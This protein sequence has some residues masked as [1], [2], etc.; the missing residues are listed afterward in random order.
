MKVL[1]LQDIYISYQKFYSAIFSSFPL[2]TIPPLLCI[3][4]KNT[5]HFSTTSSAKLH[6]ALLQLGLN[7]VEARDF[8]S[9]ARQLSVNGRATRKR[10]IEFNWESNAKREQKVFATSSAPSPDGFVYSK[11]HQPYL[12][13]AL[14]RMTCVNCRINRTE[15][16][17]QFTLSAA[18][19]HVQ[20]MRIMHFSSNRLAPDCSTNNFSR[21]LCLREL[22]E[23]LI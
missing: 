5:A 21:M 11:R 16:I 20:P 6:I 14:C 8:L 9:G 18:N 3:H 7:V 4:S 23:G 17:I 10:V 19:L 2:Q 15:P 1:E 13:C 12:V 22:R